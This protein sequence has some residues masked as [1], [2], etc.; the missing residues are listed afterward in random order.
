MEA[1]TTLRFLVDREG[2]RDN[3]V[4]I[5]KK[6]FKNAYRKLVL[7]LSTIEEAQNDK[8]KRIVKQKWG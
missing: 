5:K 8:L 2:G 1:T 7:L 3:L 4:K 6:K